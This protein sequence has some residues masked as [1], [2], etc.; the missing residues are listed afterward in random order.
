MKTK[1]NKHLHPD[2]TRF[3]AWARAELTKARLVKINNDYDGDSVTSTWKPL[4]FGDMVWRPEL[5]A[6]S[7]ISRDSNTP[8][9]LVVQPRRPFIKNEDRSVLMAGTVIDIPPEVNNLLKEIRDRR[10]KFNKK[11]NDSYRDHISKKIN[12][13]SLSGSAVSKSVT[14][15]IDTA[16]ILSPITK[17]FNTI[18]TIGELTNMLGNIYPVDYK[19]GFDLYFMQKLM[20]NKNE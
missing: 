11:L 15:P 18:P 4:H 19:S 2:S 9:D 14:I 5:F 16:G 13:N 20:E 6:T 10:I 7:P 1:R 17:G 3:L 8:K 12:R